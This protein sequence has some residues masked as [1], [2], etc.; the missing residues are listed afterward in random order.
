MNKIL[1]DFLR[2]VK[3]DTQSSEESETTPSTL[4]QYDLL[5]VL[6]KELKDLGVE[7]GIDQYGRLYGHIDG[8]SSLEC[9]GLCAHVDTALECSGANVKPQIIESYDGK[10][11]LLGSSGYVLSPKEFKK[12]SEC[13]GKTI[14]TT[15]GNTLL[16]ADD[17]AGVAI[18]MD[19]IRNVLSMP[20]DKRRPLSVLFTPDEEVGRGPEHF[21]CKKYGCK[22]AYTIDGD[23]PKYISFENFNAKSCEIK[24]IG[25][26]IHP[27]EGKG[28]LLNAALILCEF[29][30]L[31]PEKQTPYYTEN[32]EG[33]NHL[34][35]I[36]GA[37]EEA[38]A[39]YILRNHDSK[40]LEQQVKDF[41]NAKAL[42]ENKYPGCKVE[43]TFKDQYKNM[44]EIVSKNPAAKNTIE[45]V[46]N[47][48]GIKFEYDPIRGG[49]DGA[50]F[51]FLGCPTPNLGTGSY[52]HH[53]RYEYAVLEEMELMSK[54]ITEMYKM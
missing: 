49:T 15:D 51:S 50:T 12:L 5:K 20:V 35:G 45:A 9:V 30:G 16:G 17:K 13:K 46:Y 54:I 53:G 41:E 37:V 34:V 3:I 26:S 29:A 23:D 28:K 42:I 4:K 24:V 19:V 1:E 22:F 38:N 36:S 25:K 52:N 2:Y 6:E 8:N 43:L 11:I 18:I 48:L 21:D 14:I 33:F 47:K 31:L 40:I 39:S 10:D 27:G 44:H 32:R 7:Y